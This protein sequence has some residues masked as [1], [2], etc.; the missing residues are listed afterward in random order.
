MELMFVWVV[1][2]LVSAYS[3]FSY[4]SAKGW[5]VTST[6]RNDLVFEHRN[7][8]YG[9]YQLRKSYNKRLTLIMLGMIL[10]FALGALV[11]FIVRNLPKEEVEAPKGSDKTWTV[12]PPRGFA[13]STSDNTAATT[14]R[15]N[16][17]IY[18]P[19]D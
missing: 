3:L 11:L 10:A 15:K 17:G 4:V 19:S 5:L 7:K 6:D 16:D 12:Q 2:G 13:T 14:F 1:V 18:T 8:E 9:A